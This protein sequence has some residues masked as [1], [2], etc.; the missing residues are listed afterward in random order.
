MAKPISFNPEP[1]AT[2]DLLPSIFSLI[3]HSPKPFDPT[4]GLPAVADGSGLNEITAF[5]AAP[6]IW[7]ADP[8]FVAALSLD[9]PKG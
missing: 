9:L 5:I 8:D 3:Q 6:P 2:E 4:E 7:I 1:A